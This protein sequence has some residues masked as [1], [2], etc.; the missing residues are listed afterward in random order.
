MYKKDTHTHIHT[1]T[2]HIQHIHMYCNIQILDLEV[3]I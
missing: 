1:Y 2:M 3:M